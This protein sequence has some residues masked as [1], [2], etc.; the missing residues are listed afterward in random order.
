M[1]IA[2]M[3]SCLVKSGVVAT[4]GILIGLA[5]VAVFDYFRWIIIYE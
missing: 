1:N 4:T 3:V 5:M 2:L